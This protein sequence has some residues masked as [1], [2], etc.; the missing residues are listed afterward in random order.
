M[1]EA[2]LEAVQSDEQEVLQR[3]EE[4]LDSLPRFIDTREMVFDAL[5]EG[6]SDYA[7]ARR[8]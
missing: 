2:V 8:G 3:A 5:V 1:F 4:L 6:I 7:A